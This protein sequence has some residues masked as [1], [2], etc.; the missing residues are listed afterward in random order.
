M[1]MTGCV[2]H[3]LLHEH[4]AD[5]RIVLATMLHKHVLPLGSR[6]VFIAPKHHITPSHRTTMS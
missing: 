5:L 1:I 6:W 2:R 4:H 3:D